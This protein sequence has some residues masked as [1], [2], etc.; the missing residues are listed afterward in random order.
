MPYFMYKDKKIFFEQYGNGIPLLLLHGNSLSSRMFLP[1]IDELQKYTKVILIDFLGNGY[2]DRVSD[3]SDDLWY[4]EAQQA[5]SLIDYLGYSQVNL[6]GTSGG[7]LVAL[8]IALERP[9]LIGKVI[10][11]SFEG[12]SPLDSF[13]MNIHQDRA[14]SKKNPWLK[15]LYQQNHGNDWENVVDNDTLAIYTHYQ[16]HKTFFHKKLCELRLPVLLTGSKEDEFMSG[17]FFEKVYGNLSIENK[18]IHIFE[19]GGHPAMISNKDTFI[20]L[21]IHFLKNT[22]R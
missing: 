3:I 1:M 6:L 19:H 15:T 7:A 16:N 13:V 8:N 10:A 18:K 21:V 11:D 9:D 5:I 12:E 2:S 4:D 20:P 22:E 17:N 14:L